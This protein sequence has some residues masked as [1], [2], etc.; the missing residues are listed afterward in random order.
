[1]TDDEEDDAEATDQSWETEDEE[2]EE[3]E[4]DDDEEEEGIRIEPIINMNEPRDG[5]RGLV[6]AREA[7]LGLSRQEDAG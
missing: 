3:E 7:H 5:Q 1:L 2:E 4:E 6:A